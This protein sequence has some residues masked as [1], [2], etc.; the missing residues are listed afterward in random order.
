VTVRLRPLSLLNAKARVLERTA[1]GFACLSV[2][3]G[4]GLVGFGSTSIVRGGVG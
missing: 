3:R 2:A 1:R 4:A